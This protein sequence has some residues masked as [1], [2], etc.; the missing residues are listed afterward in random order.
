MRLG[1]SIA[2]GAGGTALT[3]TGAFLGL[4][5]WMAG[6][7]KHG[8]AWSLATKTDFWSGLGLVLV[9]LATILLYRAELAQRLASRGI[10]SRKPQ[11]EAERPEPV[12]AAAPEPMT[13]AALLA[14][15][16]EVVQEV[17]SEQGGE[18]AWP[19]DAAGPGVDEAELVRLA[20]TLLHEIQSEKPEA[21]RTPAAP[22]EPEKPL[23]LMSE[24]ELA[25]MASNLL[26]EIQRTQQ[27]RQWVPAR[28]EDTRE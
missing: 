8:Q 1:R 9:G 4:S 27:E 26:E 11:L 12:A 20:T 15:A 14:L 6:F 5:P 23:A 28:K 24:A 21:D 7:A 25:R 13:D 22:S 10:T 2:A 18:T 3:L 19:V 17:Q 16:S